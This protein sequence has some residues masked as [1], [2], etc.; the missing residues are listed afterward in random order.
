MILLTSFKGKEFYLNPDL[1]YRI[2]ETPD[3][4]I[5]LVDGKTLVVRDTVFEI[6]E[7]IIE[8][9]H[10]IFSGENLFEGNN[11]GNNEEE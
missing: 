1:I 5:T 9:R 7:A 8:Y 2:D 3:T 4:V 6:R 11:E 10:R